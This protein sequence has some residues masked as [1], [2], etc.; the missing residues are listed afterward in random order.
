MPKKLLLATRQDDGTLAFTPD[1]LA[2]FLHTNAT[3]PKLHRLS[4]PL[5]LLLDLSKRSHFLATELAQVRAA[6]TC[7]SLPI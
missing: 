6:F 2:C 5:P 4:L 1:Q 7:C 3:D